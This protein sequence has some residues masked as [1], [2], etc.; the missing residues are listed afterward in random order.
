M[1]VY[2]WAHDAVVAHSLAPFTKHQ[3]EKPWHNKPKS[4]HINIAHVYSY[5]TD[6]EQK[7][8][9]ESAYVYVYVYVYVHTHIHVIS[10]SHMRGASY[11][12]TTPPASGTPHVP[13]SVRVP[14]DMVTGAWPTPARVCFVFVCV[15][16][17]GFM[18]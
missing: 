7:R 11:T 1:H 5:M 4:F 14:I 2:L 12:K 13:Q 3:N 18:W 9:T 6:V 10:Y 8:K 17:S 15:L 16:M